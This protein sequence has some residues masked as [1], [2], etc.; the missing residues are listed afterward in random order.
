MSDLVDRFLG[1]AKAK[2]PEVFSSLATSLLEEGTEPPIR[3]T[4]SD[5]RRAR[6]LAKKL[7]RSRESADWVELRKPAGRNALILAA[8]LISRDDSAE[9]AIVGLGTGTKTG[10]SFVKEVFATRGKSGSVSLPVSVRARIRGHLEEA[11]GGEFIHIHNHPDNLG[12]LVKNQLLGEAPIASWADRRFHFEY[13]LLNDDLNRNAQRPRQ[14]R[15][16]LLENGFASPYRLA[17]PPELVV[18]VVEELRRAGLVQRKTSEVVEAM[19]RLGLRADPRLV[20][21]LTG[22]R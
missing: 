2:G 19:S 3:P 9:W 16:Y 5:A 10:R 20:E 17:A 8:N 4:H 18:Q 15:C 12:R 7:L 13:E 21:K 6:K 1:I 14:L 11:E 22:Q